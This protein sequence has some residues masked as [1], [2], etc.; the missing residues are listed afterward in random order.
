MCIP[1]DIPV[2]HADISVDNVDISVHNVNIPMDNSIQNTCTSKEPITFM[3][4]FK[5]YNIHN[6]LG[7]EK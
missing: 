1:L 5:K 6:K 4:Y 2:D 7:T 3:S